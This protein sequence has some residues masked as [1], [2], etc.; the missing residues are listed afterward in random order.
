MPEVSRFLGIL[1]A[2]YYNDHAP[3]H[4]HAKYG[5]YEVV[6]RIDDGVVDGRF[7]RRAL[8]LVLEWYD[9]HRSELAENWDLARQRKPLRRIDPLE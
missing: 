8:N 3:P 2:M 9:L 6:V 7:P 5:A 4:F 1:I